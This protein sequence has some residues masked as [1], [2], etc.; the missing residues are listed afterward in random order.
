MPIYMDRHQ[1]EGLTRQQVADQHVAD[2]KIQDK[3]NCNFITYWFDEERDTV[4]CLVDA[5]NM[6]AV[7][8]AHDDAH[9][10]VHSQIIEVDPELV[11]AF[12]GRVSHPSS[13]V[14]DLAVD[15][16]FRAVMFT[17]LEG[18]TRMISDLGD[19]RA[20]EL[21][22]IHNSL[23]RE[24][25]RAHSGREIKHTGDGFMASFTSAVSAVECAIAIQQSIAKHNAESP[26]EQM[27]IRIG[28]SAG[29]PVHNDNQLYGASVNLAARLCAH[30]P[31]GS[32]LVA[33]IIR[34]L[35]MGKK[36]PIV[37]R[38]EFIPKGFERPIPILEVSWMSS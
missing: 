35:T 18:S 2:V 14:D 13:R 3:Y 30:A 25:L 21:L 23:T 5:P 33:P 12:L 7:E 24:A 37:D 34:E 27:L 16:A 26:E 11:Q 4:F 9:G 8:K 38:G 31:P 20:I 19:K 28:I 22:R 6:R 17:D 36:V 32:I 29:E 1:G 15:S 10:F